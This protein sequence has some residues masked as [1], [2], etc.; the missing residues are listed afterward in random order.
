MELNTKEWI[1]KRKF[2][3]CVLYLKYRPLEALVC[4]RKFL[5]KATK[6]PFLRKITTEWYG[7]WHVKIGI[8]FSSARQQ[9]QNSSVKNWKVQFIKM[10]I[11]D[12]DSSSSKLDLK[13]FQEIFDKAEPGVNIDSLEV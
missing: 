4:V 3:D 5:L 7:F 10:G 13:L 9:Y 6:L 11:N 1:I 2:S 12:L 8:E